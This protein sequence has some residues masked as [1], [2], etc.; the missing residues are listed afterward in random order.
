MA[1][2]GNTPGGEAA[3]KRLRRKILI[4]PTSF[5]VGN[6]FFG[7]YSVVCSLRGDYDSAAKLIG[8]SWLCDV[9]DGRIARLTNATS[10]F[11]LQLDSLADVIAFGMAPAVLLMTWGLQPAERNGIL[12]VSAFI[13]LI[14]AAMRLARF[15][16]SAQSLKHFVGMPTPAAGTLIAALV[17]MFPQRVVRPSIAWVLAGLACGL[18]ALMIST[19]RHPSLKFIGL[20]K[21][22]SHF[23]VFI[24]AIIIGLVYMFSQV[25]LLAITTAYASSGLVMK[26]YSLARRKRGPDGMALHT[27]DPTS[28]HHG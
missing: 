1:K 21:G 27:S 7:F 5:T 25:V 15:N 26:L 6:I 22:R 8:L 20:T 14:C 2:W 9:L 24:L 16:V 4:L 13:Y 3:P 19:L 18:G 12:W 17:H 10:D 28:E 23:N 11:G